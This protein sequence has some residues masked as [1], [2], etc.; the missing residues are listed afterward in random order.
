MRIRIPLT[1]EVSKWDV[2]D[3]LEENV[4]MM[5]VSHEEVSHYGMGWG[6][7]YDFELT[8]YAIYVSIDDERLAT[9]L[10]LRWA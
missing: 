7:G 10:T 8:S 3:W 2:I 4:G 9:L 5:A 1:Q 6:D